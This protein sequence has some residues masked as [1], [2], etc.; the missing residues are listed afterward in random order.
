M[1]G[2][3]ERPSS[4][5]SGRLS[6]SSLVEWLFGILPFGYQGDLL[7]EGKPQHQPDIDFASN[8]GRED[9]AAAANVGAIQLLSNMFSATHSSLP[10]TL[11]Y[12]RRARDTDAETP[13][14]GVLHHFIRDIFPAR[15]SAIAHPLAAPS[16][17]V[18]ADYDGFHRHAS[19]LRRMNRSSFP[20]S[21]DQ[22]LPT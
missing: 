1:R 22:M 5:E 20:A 9:L 4:R 3:N 12:A 18:L 2:Q 19:E 17:P 7:R 6:T 14:G 15:P 11:P 16:V 21:L 10:G 13:R 8:G